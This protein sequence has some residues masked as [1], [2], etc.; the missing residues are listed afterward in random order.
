MSDNDITLDAESFKV[1]ASEKVSTGEYE[2]ADY[3][4]TLEG[5]IDGDAPISNG[6]RR[7]IKA[8][9]LAAQRDLQEVVERSAE[10]RLRVDGSENWGV[11]EE[12]GD[13]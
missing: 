3:H 12:A 13:E 7:A 5:S 11:P 10:N 1:H 8:R 4:A 6:T 2:S 9:L